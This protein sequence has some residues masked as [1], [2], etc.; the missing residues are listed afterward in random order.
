MIFVTVITTSNAPL[1]P[2]SLQSMPVMGH[3]NRINS[4]DWEQASKS[5][6]GHLGGSALALGAMEGLL[7]DIAPSVAAAVEQAIILYYPLQ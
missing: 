4:F 3:F 2:Q 5:R 7:K 6:G 1:Q